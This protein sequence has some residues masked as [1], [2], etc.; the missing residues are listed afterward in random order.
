MSKAH[1]KRG[2]F[3]TGE[4]HR[5]KAPMF[6]FYYLQFLISFQKIKNIGR[7]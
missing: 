1:L 4:K 3:S 6:L 7:A 2:A 5:V